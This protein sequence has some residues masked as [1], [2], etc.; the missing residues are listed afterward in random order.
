MN[1]S[2]PEGPSPRRFRFSLQTV[3]FLFALAACGITIWQLWREV[4]PLRAEVRR[5]RDDVGQL[6]IDDPTKVHIIQARQP[7][8]LT[9]RWRLS[10]PKGRT[11]KLMWNG[12]HIPK[13]GFA[14]PDAW[15]LVFDAGEAMVE[16]RITKDPQTD[17]WR[18]RLWHN[19]HNLGDY[20]QKWV[21][22][23]PH[24]RNSRHEGVGMQT[25]V[26]NPD[27]PI[28]IARHRYGPF[29]P[30]SDD[31]PDPALGFMIWL[32]PQ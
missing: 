32:E 17:T 20:E 12:R 2:A 30:K 21:E 26:F 22:W 9:W 31:I 29:A 15:T 1:E 13:T 8:E 19:G 11:Y 5:L 24:A 10:I 6:T 16:F 28:V 4:G 7:D 27:A 3:L 23:K 14:T 18:G 25:M